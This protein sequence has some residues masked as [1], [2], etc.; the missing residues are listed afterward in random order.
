MER[1][2]VRSKCDMIQHLPFQRYFLTLRVYMIY[3]IALQI[4]RVNSQCEKVSLKG[5]YE[6]L[7]HIT[8]AS[9]RQSFHL[10]IADSGLLHSGYF[11]QI[12]CMVRS[13]F[14]HWITK[15]FICVSFPRDLQPDRN[16]F[17][18]E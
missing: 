7:N 11:N 17:L 4:N 9:C 10:S 8:F 1:L 12:T 5:S 16:N 14:Q 15:V 18:L 3:M 13:H 6:M 2:L